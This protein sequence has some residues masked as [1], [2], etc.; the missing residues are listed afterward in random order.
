MHEPRYV[1][2]QE[3]TRGGGEREQVVYAW[4]VATPFLPSEGCLWFLRELRPPTTAACSSPLPLAIRGERR[5]AAHLR[6]QI[7][8]GRRQMCERCS[9]QTEKRTDRRTVLYH[10]WAPCA[11]ASTAWMPYGLSNPRKQSHSHCLEKYCRRRPF[12]LPAIS[13]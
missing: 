5:A 4:R 12:P 9:I 10:N 7:G 6:N 3:H 1:V 2:V 8:R 11:T 13:W